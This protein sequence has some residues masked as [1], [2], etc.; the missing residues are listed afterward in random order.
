MYVLAQNRKEGI[1]IDYGGFYHAEKPNPHDTLKRTCMSKYY[2][3][4]K[5]A[6]KNP[7]KIPEYC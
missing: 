2:T 7:C 5:Y 3:L 4:S 6:R 1:L